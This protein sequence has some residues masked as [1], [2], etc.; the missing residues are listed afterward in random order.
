M[1]VKRRATWLLLVSTLFE[2]PDLGVVLP[3][4]SMV[5]TTTTASARGVL[6]RT[7]KVVASQLHLGSDKA[8]GMLA[9]FPPMPYHAASEGLVPREIQTLV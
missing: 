5:M 9:G 4:T 2:L 7:D 3:S 6:V 8:S 1:G